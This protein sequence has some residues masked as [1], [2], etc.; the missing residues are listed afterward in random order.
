M[1]ILYERDKK[2]FMWIAPLCTLKSTVGHTHTHSRKMRNTDTHTHI[3]RAKPMFLNVIRWNELGPDWLCLFSKRALFVLALLQKETCGLKECANLLSAF[4]CTWKSTVTAHPDKYETRNGHPNQIRILN[5]HHRSLFKWLIRTETLTSQDSD[6]CVHLC[7]CVVIGMKSESLLVKVLWLPPP[8]FAGFIWKARIAISFRTPHK[9]TNAHTNRNPDLSTFLFKGAIWKETCDDQSGFRFHSED[10]TNAQMH[11][12]IGFDSFCFEG[13]IWKESYDD[14]SG[15]PDW[16]PMTKQMHKYTYKL[17][18]YT[19]KFESWHKEPFEK[20]RVMIIL[21]S[22]VLSHDHSESH[23][24]WNG[25][26]THTHSQKHL[27]NTGTHTHIDRT[28]PHLCLM[29]SMCVC[30][31]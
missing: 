10:H 8:P 28:R 16:N 14:H 29:R 27:R 2:S 20:S 6:L 13:A 30:V 19:Y 1:N 21:N 23:L 31:L 17:Y 26:C 3:V 7:I 11:T 9:C 18:K 15:L 22:D 5:C 24:F 25:L 4:L 12:Q